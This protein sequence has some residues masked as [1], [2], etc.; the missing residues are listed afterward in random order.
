M[1]TANRHS[2]LGKPSYGKSPHG[3]PPLGKSPLGKP[4]LGKPPLGKPSHAIHIL[5]LANCKSPLGTW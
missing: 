3:K 2:A 1:Q 5:Q 4:S